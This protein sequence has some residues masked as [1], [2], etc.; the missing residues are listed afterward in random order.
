MV[1]V[2][3][4]LNGL[5]IVNGCGDLEHVIRLGRNRNEVIENSQAN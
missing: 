5:S 3:E 4:S 2:Q 1:N